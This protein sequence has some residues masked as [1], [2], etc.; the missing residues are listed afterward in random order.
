MTGK[1]KNLKT[2][3]IDMIQPKERTSEKKRKREKKSRMGGEQRDNVIKTSDMN[4]WGPRKGVGREGR[5]G[6]SS[7]G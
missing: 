5:P 6:C 2:E 3:P 1:I 7:V 4:T